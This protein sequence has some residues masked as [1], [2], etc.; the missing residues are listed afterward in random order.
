MKKIILTLFFMIFIIIYHINYLSLDN[1]Y[2]MEMSMLNYIISILSSTYILFIIVIFIIGLQSININYY[3]FSFKNYYALKDNNKFTINYLKIWLN[4]Y[5][6]V[7]LIVTVSL[8]IVILIYI[9]GYWEILALIFIK[10]GL[11]IKLKG[12]TTLAGAMVKIGGKKALVYST[13]GMLLKR[14]LIDVFSK[15]F[16]KHSVTRYKNTLIHIIHLKINDVKNASIIKKINAI[17]GLFLSI[18]MIY[19]FWTKFLSVAIQKIAYAFIYPLLSFLFSLLSY[20]FTFLSSFFT[21]IFEI[22]LLGFFIE[23][24]KRFYF[25]KE[26]LK[27]VDNFFR[28]IWKLIIFI[29]SILNHFHLSP[30]TQLIIYSNKI[31]KKLE[32]YIDKGI[33]SINKITRN[34]LRYVSIIE[35]ISQ[36]R[37]YYQKSK[38]RVYNQENFYKKTLNFLLNKKQYNYKI[39]RAKRLEKIRLKNSKKISERRLKNL[40]KKIKPIKR[41]MPFNNISDYYENPNTY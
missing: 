25:G 41:H 17:V 31:N 21:T 36:K 23:Y 26:I 18:P 38:K 9:F 11:G 16:I 22:L 3:I 15:F 37:F 6:K 10:F 24:M 27:K 20:S 7:L 40:N 4:L 35:K 12:I 13:M 14:Y 34:R 30:R 8:L 39:A 28:L 1:V 2:H 5:K 19:I 29:D 33:N 32:E